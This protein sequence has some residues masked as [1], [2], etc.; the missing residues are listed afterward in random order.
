MVSGFITNAHIT[1][2]SQNTVIPK[3]LM[4]EGYE[5]YSYIILFGTLIGMLP[6]VL[7]SMLS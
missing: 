5:V 7:D 3:A 6:P 2:E 4:I 1:E